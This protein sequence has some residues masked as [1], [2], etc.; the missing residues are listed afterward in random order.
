MN[1]Q[2]DSYV[3]WCRYTDKSI[4]TCDSD[5]EGAFRVYRRG[6]DPDI[7]VQFDQMAD[8][9]DDIRKILDS[10][11][12]ASRLNCLKAIRQRI[13]FNIPDTPSNFS[14]AGDEPLSR[15]ECPF[16]YCDQPSPYNECQPVCRHSK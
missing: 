14:H 5:E 3:A 10:T 11:T 2:L 13:N 4:V 16:N 15:P 1:E 9:L 7:M 6:D 12:Y 8:C